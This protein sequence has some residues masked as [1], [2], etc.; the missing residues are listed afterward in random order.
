MKRIAVIM[1]AAASIAVAEEGNP[2]PAART[3]PERGPTEAAAHRAALQERVEAIERCVASNDMAGV[4]RELNAVDWREIE[5]VKAATK[6]LAKSLPKGKPGAEMRRQLKTKYSLMSDDLEAISDLDGA[7]PYPVKIVRVQ[8]LKLST[9][10]IASLV[11]VPVD[12]GALAID[13]LSVPYLSVDGLTVPCIDARAIPI[14]FIAVGD[15]AFSDAMGTWEARWNI[16][17]DAVGP[18]G[19]RIVPHPATV[20]GMARAALMQAIEDQG[21]TKETEAAWQAYYNDLATALSRRERLKRN[22]SRR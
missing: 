13:G 12:I 8:I 19:V 2:P 11:F 18:E 4:Q 14:A 1:L 6:L 7:K 5:D 15:S 3:P 22:P 10:E 20:L 21:W 16:V 9:A 17:L